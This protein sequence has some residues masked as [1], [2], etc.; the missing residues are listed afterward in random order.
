MAF[1]AHL[2]A[3]RS[4]LGGLGDVLGQ[5]GGVLTSPEVTKTATTYL[6]YLSQ[7]DA[8]KAAQKKADQEGRVAAAY[9][10]AQ[11]ELLSKNPS[12]ALYGPQAFNAYDPGGYLTAFYR[13]TSSP[14][15]TAPGGAPAPGANPAPTPAGSDDSLLI[16]LGLIFALGVLS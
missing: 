11:V 5:I 16:V 13:G 9:T 7:R 8:A 12:L 14:V 4:V 6:N 10:N 3:P 15:Y 1:D 2:P